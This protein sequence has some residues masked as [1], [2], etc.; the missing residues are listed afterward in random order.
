MV[1]PVV[2]VAPVDPVAPV[3]PLPLIEPGGGFNSGMLGVALPEPP[4]LAITMPT[5]SPVM[6]AASAIRPKRRKTMSAGLGG[7]GLGGFDERRQP[8]EAVRAIAEVPA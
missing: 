5:I 2:P 6:T 8:A 7:P 1:A 3:V 4:A